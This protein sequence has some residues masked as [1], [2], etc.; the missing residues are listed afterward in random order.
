MWQVNVAQEAE[1]VVR[2][3]HENSMYQQIKVQSNE[4][5]R[6]SVTERTKTTTSLPIAKTV[7]KDKKKNY[8]NQRRKRNMTM[9][10][11]KEGEIVNIS[12]AIRTI[13]KKSP[14]CHEKVEE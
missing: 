8:N 10:K 11:T 2:K 13:W 9:D 1:I 4:K 14:R 5:P 3:Q 7:N 12:T 6:Q